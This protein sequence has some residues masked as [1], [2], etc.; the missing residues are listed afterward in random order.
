MQFFS[1]FG[2]R[3]EK[4][5]FL[6]YLERGEYTIA[7][8]SYGAQKALQEALAR[9][10]RSMRVDKLQ[11]LSPA[12]FDHL[13]K[14]KKSAELV[15][16]AKNS[17]LYMRFFYKKAAYPA[18]LNLEKFKA[19]PSLAQLRELLFFRW[20]REALQRLVDAGLEI[21][22]FLGEQ[23]KIVDTQKAKEFF[24]QYA[25]CYTIKGAGHLLKGRDG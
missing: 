1:G 19:T 10:D 14:S 20:E 23:D 4:I 22:V 2:F 6:E 15:A 5:L 24:V 17:E 7:G 25:T 12:Y 11:L 21:E 8:F 13:P 16:F 18:T 3:N 9:V